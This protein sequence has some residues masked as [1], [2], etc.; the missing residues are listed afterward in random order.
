[1]Q[2][3]NLFVIARLWTM[4]RSARVRC[5]RARDARKAL[6]RNNARPVMGRECV[7]SDRECS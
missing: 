7:K 3:G 5:A 4:R 2:E 1:M 6:S